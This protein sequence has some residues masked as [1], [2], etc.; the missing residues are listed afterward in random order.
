MLLFVAAE[1]EYIPTI[2]AH[3]GSQLIECG[4]A[5]TTL[6]PWALATSPL[7]SPEELSEVLRKHTLR[8]ASALV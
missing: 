7:V 8:W 3:A 5:D 4:V 2:P 6:V 1:A